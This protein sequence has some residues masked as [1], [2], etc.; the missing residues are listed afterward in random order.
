MPSA[1]GRPFRVGALAVS[2]DV[3]HVEAA[4]H[5][6]ERRRDDGVAAGRREQVVGGEQ[7]LLRLGDGLAAERHVDGHLVAVEVGV[8]GRADERVQLDGAALR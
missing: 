5:H 3:G 7:D 1:H 8:E 2:V 6:V 4:E